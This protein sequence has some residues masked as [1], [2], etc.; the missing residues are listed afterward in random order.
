MNDT[1]PLTKLE[2]SVLAAL[3]TYSNVHRGSGHFSIVTT[4]LYEKAREI[5]LEYLRLNKRKYIVIFCT[6]RRAALLTE[7]L[8]PGRFQSL[9]SRDF[10]LS[11]GIRA[12]AVE[13]KALPKGAPFQTGG[14][15]TKL[16]SSDWVIWAE[17]PDKFEA[18]TPAIINV[19]ALARALLLVREY[20]KDFF[21]ANAGRMMAAS[22]ILYRDDLEIFTGK[23]LLD[24]LRQTL[25]GRNVLIPTTYGNKPFINLDNAA[26][27]PTFEPIWKV[28]KDT[29]LQPEKIQ[30]E[31]IQEVR[32]VCSEIL[33]APHDV[34]DVVFTSNT[35]EAI[36]LAAE[37]LAHES[38]EDYEPVVITT[39]LEH[40]SNDLPWRNFHLIRLSVDGDGFFDLNEL[41]KIL[42]A[43]NR[44]GQYGKKRVILVAVSGA[45]NVLGIFN[46]L[47]E[48][49]RIVH[50][51]DARLLVDAAQMVAHRL[52][53][54]AETGIDYL[55]FSA[56]KVYAPFGTGALIVKKGLLSFSPAEMELIHSSGEE[57][58]GG[59][60]ALGKSL[61]LLKRIGFDLVRKEEQ[62]LT[63]RTLQGMM[64][65]E[66]VTVYG[67][68]DT[69]SA[70]FNNRGGVIVFGI[71]GKIPFSIAKELAWRGGIGVRVGCHCAHIIIKRILN[72]NH[73]LE[74]FQRIMQTIL[75]GMKFPGLV[76][77][78]LGI[79]NTKEDVDSFIVTLG[80]I[81][82]KR[83]PGY[84][85]AEMKK[86]IAEYT[87]SC[88]KKIYF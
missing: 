30:R 51:Y 20:G 66:R 8:R 37:S 48:I 24:K 52:V 60:A 33:G 57:N 2:Q 68:R 29:W 77:I 79:Q 73:G 44:K 14:G 41:E 35:T 65:V 72:V 84:S 87:A 13:K 11:I 61:L 26:S 53:D 31:I 38:A 21:Q 88:E 74:R 49:S 82:G 18:G 3:E 32:S 78:S 36:N 25:I 12:I 64:Q 69:D 67:I 15:T 9:S 86:R 80:E 40:S 50:R 27:T 10:G 22:D 43:Y 54:A 70:K 17:A 76:R 55:A 62:S 28:V 71:K 85:G 23:E 42:S 45:S 58:A 75:P 39:F 46:D 19:I 63:A 6:Q 83:K 34:Y 16:I 81:A 47:M 59:I 5:V 56:H 1:Q 7:Q 4:H